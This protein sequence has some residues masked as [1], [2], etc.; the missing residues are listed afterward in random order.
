MYSHKILYWRGQNGFFLKGNFAPILTIYLARIETN[1]NHTCEIN[2]NYIYIYLF[3]YLYVL[4]MS[5][6]S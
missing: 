5:S 3:I 4:F 1:S 2:L 6:F